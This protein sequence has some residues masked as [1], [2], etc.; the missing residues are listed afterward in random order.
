M[1][2]ATEITLKIQLQT[3]VTCSSHIRKLFIAVTA[4]ADLRALAMRRIARVLYIEAWW[5]RKFRWWKL[6]WMADFL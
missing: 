1:K 5:F 3:H 2:V 4:T 6:A